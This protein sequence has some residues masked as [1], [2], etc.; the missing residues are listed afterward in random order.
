MNGNVTTKL[1]ADFVNACMSAVIDTCT[2]ELHQAP[3]VGQVLIS[4]DRL[5]SAGASVILGV[6]GQVRGALIF[7]MEERI[8]KMVASIRA[9]APVQMFDERAE[10]AVI[11]LGNLASERVNAVLEQ[12]GY[13]IALSPPSLVT[14]YGLLLTDP[15][16]PRLVVPLEFTFASIRV[17]LAM[18]EI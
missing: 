8:A 18:Q 6:T 16:V 9:K 12:R 1:N 5:L 13:Q 15:E 2:R 14:G 3:G 10:R 7:D 17:H 11:E 4:R